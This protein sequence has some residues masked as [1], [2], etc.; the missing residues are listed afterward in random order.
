M[1]RSIVASLM[2]VALIGVIA[3]C[4]RKVV[5]ENADDGGSSNCFTCHTE[6]N[7]AFL[8]AQGEWAN[9]VH[10][11]G[12][13]VDY[14]NRGGGSDCTRCHNHAGFIEF[15]TT[16]SLS[17][18]YDQ[19]SAI[20]CF[21]CHAP[22]ETGTMDLRTV[23][24]YTLDNL[25]SFD[26]GK[27]NLCVNCHHSRGSGTTFA[28]GYVITSSRF[29]P[30]HGPQGDMIQGTNGYQ[31]FP[32]YTLQTSTHST[33]VRDAC[34]GC[35]MG[36]ATSHDGYA[37]GG[38]SWNMVDDET[39]SNIVGYCTPCHAG[40]T[41][42]TGYN[43]IAPADYDGDAAIEGYQS[44]FE[45][46]LARLKAELVTDGLINNATDGSIPQTVADR[47]KVGALWNYKFAE[48]DQSRGI[49]NF[50]YIKSLMEA[51]IAYLQAN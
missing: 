25:V 10:A 38:H 20:H 23:A 12:S 8:Q 30:H 28:D 9:S 49:H 7:T 6:S 39:G 4:E 51:S 31:G 19:V 17:A 18:P 27:G 34:A 11:S 48:E 50:K 45:G 5:V 2:I 24:A 15:L 46:L 21:T 43:F 13:N 16:G 36:S 26:H 42:T 22:H 29:G 3:G 35:H 40:A 37:I 32:G 14:T 44:E 41:S 1:K 47:H 33:V